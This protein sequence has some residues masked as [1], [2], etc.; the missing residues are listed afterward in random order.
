[1]EVAIADKNLTRIVGTGDFYNKINENCSEDSLFAKVIENG[2]YI[3]NLTENKYCINCSDR[4]NCPEFA[5]MSYPIRSDGEVIGVVSFASFDP[6]QTDIMRVKKDEYFNMLKESSRIVEQ[7][8]TNIK[9]GNKFKKDIAEVDEIIN[10]LNKGILILNSD[11]QIIHI[12]A[13]ALQS[14]DLSLSDDKIAQQHIN[15]FIEGI[16]LRDRGNDELIG[17][18]EINGEKVRVIYTVNKITIT[19]SKY[20]L[21]ISFDIISDIINIAKTYENKEK[22]YFKDII[23]NS[24][25]LLKAINKSKIAA[26]T[27]STI[28][29]QGDSGTGK[30]L[31]ARSIHNE[32]LRKSGPFVAINCGSIPENLIESELFGYE[33]GAFTGANING[34]KG[35]IELANNGTLFLDEIGDL[36][37][38]LQTRLLRVLQ[39]RTIDRLGGE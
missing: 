2:E 17:C 29:L 39:E 11:K 4:K 16:E 15:D 26:S 24:K 1:I 27:D 30:E 10:G 36:P 32:S 23:G 25:P 37:P 34:K 5:N 21:M 19:D 20:S 38:Y 14:L 35:K 6:D 18:W 8:I 28:L 13:K 9:I 33:K 31:F 3:I 7:E 22:I 12:N